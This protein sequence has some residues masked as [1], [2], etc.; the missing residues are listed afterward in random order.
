MTAIEIACRIC[1]SQPYELCRNSD[2]SPCSF[3]HAARLEDA[4]AISEPSKSVDP[5]LADKAFEDV[6][7][8]I[9]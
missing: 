2:R 1:S 5:A 9:A 4:A 3:T 6:M 7:D 8:E